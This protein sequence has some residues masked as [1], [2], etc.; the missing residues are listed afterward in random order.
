MLQ[1][2]FKGNWL[3]RIFKIKVDWVKNKIFGF[4]VYGLL[5]LILTGCTKGVTYHP[6][7]ISNTVF[8]TLRVKTEQADAPSFI[9]VIEHNQTF[10]TTDQH[11]YERLSAKIVHPDRSGHYQVKFNNGVVQLE[12]MFIAPRHYLL[13]SRFNRTLGVEAYEFN[14]LLTIDP[15]WNEN[16]DYSLKPVLAEYIIE[17]RFYM[18][19]KDQL[20][21]GKWLDSATQISTKQNGLE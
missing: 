10:L 1:A 18:P 2:G 19:D 13:T 8:G 11:R 17:P 6:G 7:V 3:H 5:L 21:L 4:I 20:F 16:F 12:L 14:P 15:Y 9:L